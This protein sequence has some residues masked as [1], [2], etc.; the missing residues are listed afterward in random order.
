MEPEALPATG[1][2]GIFLTDDPSDEFAQ[3]NLNVTEVV[4][5][6]GEGQPSLYQGSKKIDLLDLTNYNEPIAFGEVPAGTYSK[7][8]LYI[9]ELQ[10]V[11]HDRSANIYPQLP[12]NGKVDLLDQ[13]GFEVLPGRTVLI[14]IDVDANKSIKITETGNDRKYNFRPVVKVDIM[15]GGLPDKLA[16]IEGFV[17]E[18][19]A[20]PAGRFVVCANDM[21]DECITVDSGTATSFFD[22]DGL[23]TEFSTLMINDPV[24]VIGRYEVEPEIILNAVVVEIGGGAVQ[25]RGKV[26]SEPVDGQFLL[27]KNVGIEVIIEIQESTKYFDASGEISPASIRVG[28]NLEIEGVF[29]PQVNNIGPML[30]RAA[31]IFIETEDDQQ[32]S[33]TIIAPLDTVARSFGLSTPAGDTCVIVNE[34]ADILLVDTQASEVTMGTVEDLELGQDVDLFG[35]TAADSCFDASEVIVNLSAVL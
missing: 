16:R 17:K 1:M 21:P 23:A 34:D 31:L 15:D 19:P 9:D 14:E 8:R 4:L 27:L 18:I 32:L 7:I 6:G 30:M 35:A 24:V 11:P 29:P 25:I 5:I 33:G 3:I 26:V 20:E 2:V 13:G 28:A 22:E 10:L 12:A